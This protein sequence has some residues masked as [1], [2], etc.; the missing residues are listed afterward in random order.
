MLLQRFTNTRASLIAMLSALLLLAGCGGSAAVKSTVD[1]KQSEGINAPETASDML[2]DIPP[3]TL[4]LFE[5]ATA[6]MAGGDFVD[7]ELR[8]KEFLLQYPGYP[9]A[10]V[11]LAIIHAS[12]G[13]EA[14]A[15]ASV[16]A[17]RACY[18]AEMEIF[19]RQRP[20]I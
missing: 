20:L 5:Q 16:D 8:F 11:N 7:A 6:A 15:R 2:L 1:S 9:G 18:F 12:N 3:A 14:A 19:W 13:D 10:H 17:R 4:T